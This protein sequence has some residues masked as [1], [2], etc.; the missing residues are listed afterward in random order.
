MPNRTEREHT[1][2]QQFLKDVGITNDQFVSKKHLLTDNENEL[3]EL[4][5]RLAMARS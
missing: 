1:S 2:D 5:W 3:L 4:Q